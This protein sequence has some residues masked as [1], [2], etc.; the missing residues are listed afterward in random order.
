MNLSKE[1]KAVLEQNRVAFVRRAVRECKEAALDLSGEG[2]GDAEA[3]AIA[4][5]LAVGVFL[6]F[7]FAFSASLPRHMRSRAFCLLFV[8]HFLV[9][10]WAVSSPRNFLICSVTAL[11]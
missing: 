2:L 8:L 6:F 4:E 3:E 11:R 9:C 7:V 10:L 1:A 5:E